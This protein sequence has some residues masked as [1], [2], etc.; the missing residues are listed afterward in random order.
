MRA[1]VETVCR[2]VQALYDGGSDE[3]LATVGWALRLNQLKIGASQLVIEIVTRALAVVGIAG[4]RTD[5]PFSL[6]RHLRDAHSA[7]LMIA[8]DRMQATNA[9]LLC[10]FKDD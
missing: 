6:G 10:V 8:N 3:A 4:Y 1:T 5:T 7:P 9:A 2:D